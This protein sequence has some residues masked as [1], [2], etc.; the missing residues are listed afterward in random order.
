MEQE[1]WENVTSDYQKSEGYGEERWL[2]KV[3]D[4]CFVS[5]LHRMTGFGY[6]EWETAIRVP[7]ENIFYMICGDRRQ[8]LSNLNREELV[9]WYHDNITGNKNS[10]DTL[11]ETLSQ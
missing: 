1:I 8:E 4:D 6:M 2:R 7:S 5:V 9:V 3:D 11:L 10:M